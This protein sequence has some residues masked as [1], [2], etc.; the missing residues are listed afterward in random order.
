MGR[1]ETKGTDWAQNA[2]KEHLK[3]SSTGLLGPLPGF[4][5]LGLALAGQMVRRTSPKCGLMGDEGNKAKVPSGRSVGAAVV[6]TQTTTG[7]ASDHGVESG[8]QV[9]RQTQPSIFPHDLAGNGGRTPEELPGLT[10]GMAVT[11]TTD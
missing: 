11:K 2:G 5:G 8:P 7:N 6:V 4:E 10:S 9:G 1:R 3:M